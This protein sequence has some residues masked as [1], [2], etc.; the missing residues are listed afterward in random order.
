ML[1]SISGVK[2]E[3]PS[4]PVVASHLGAFYEAFL[5]RN[6]SSSER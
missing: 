4:D 6:Q 1:L 3:D 5:G 2:G